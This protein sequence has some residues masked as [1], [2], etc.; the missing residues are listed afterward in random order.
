MSS[1]AQR[2]DR[3]L[4]QGVR[5]AI[6][7]ALG[8]VS[9]LLLLATLTL[10]VWGGRYKSGWSYATAHTQHGAMAFPDRVILQRS[11]VTWEL[12]RGWEAQR[13]NYGITTEFDVG[14]EVRSEHSL[15]QFARFAARAD[16]RFYISE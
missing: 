6:I 15:F 12:P 9:L 13:G 1:D 7:Y 5:Q 8:G 3:R 11:L 16:R 4:W 2:D 10:W 14:S